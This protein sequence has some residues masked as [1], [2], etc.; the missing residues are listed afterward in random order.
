MTLR[1]T[2]PRIARFARPVQELRVDA[3]TA[4]QR[5][6]RP[7]G[8]WRTTGALHLVFGR[9]RRRVRGPSAVPG[10]RRTLRPPIKHRALASDGLPTALLV[11]LRAGARLY[12]RGTVGQA[13]YVIQSGIVKETVPGPEGGECIVRLVMRN[14]VTGLCA[15]LNDPHSH[16]AQVIHPGAAC[17]IPLAR[18]EH[19]RTAQPAVVERL[20]K[21]WQQAIDDADRIVAELGHGCAR[22]RLARALLHLRSSLAPG[23]PL[24]LRRTDLGDLLAIAPVSVARLL[25]DFRREGLLKE[26]QRQC[27][28][29]DTV[30]LAEIASGQA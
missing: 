3:D 29:I 23:E 21:D 7:D 18:L 4:T 6:R 17:R 15:L 12:E 22:A 11:P 16:S 30:R 1:L 13:N 10:V 27:V 28:D 20:Q 2:G 5:R 26:S 24:R 14:G 9:R 8:A 25:A 19:M